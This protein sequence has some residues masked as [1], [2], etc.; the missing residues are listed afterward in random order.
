MSYDKHHMNTSVN[1]AKFKISSSNVEM[2]P[3]LGG[4][5]DGSIQLPVPSMNRLNQTE[6]ACVL[7]VLLGFYKVYKFILVQ[8]CW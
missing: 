7:S 5:M 6:P 8:L 2:K 1:V 4:D 3:V